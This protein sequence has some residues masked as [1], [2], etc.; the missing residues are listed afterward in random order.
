M[1]SEERILM[2]IDLTP[3]PK[4]VDAVTAVEA[5]KDK[6]ESVFETQKSETVMAT[7]PTA[8]TAAPKVSWLKHVGQ[9]IG[10]ILGIVAKDAKPVADTVTQVVSVLYPGLAALAQAGDALV[11]KIALQA[12]A[13]ESVAAAAGTA[14]G[15]GAQKL[16]QV[17]GDIGPAI[18]Q[19]VANAFPGSKQ[20][21]AASKAGL[22]NAV[23]AITNEI[24][25]AAAPP[26][27]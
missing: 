19:W 6:V 22:I 26:A 1:E 17:L 2:K 16:E 25:P 24:D 20:I 4:V 15:T 7:A 10:K 5:V 14:T 9:V 18:D 3:A 21:S 11:S 23:V 13:V 27:A 8:T 12:T